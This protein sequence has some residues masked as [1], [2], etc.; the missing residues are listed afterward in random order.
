MHA[1]REAV[2]HGKESADARQRELHWLQDKGLDRLDEGGSS[3]FFS[4]QSDGKSHWVT[5]FVDAINGAGFWPPPES[6]DQSSQEAE[7]ADHD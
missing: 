2:A 5:R 3:L 1:L 7:G 4:R 6:T